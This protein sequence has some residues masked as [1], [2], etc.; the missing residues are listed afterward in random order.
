[1]TFVGCWGDPAGLL[2]NDYEVIYDWGDSLSDRPATFSGKAET[3][4]RA[5][6]TFS[7]FIEPEDERVAEGND[8]RRAGT[9]RHG[10]IAVRTGVR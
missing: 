1:M 4:K 6:A 9:P 7:A 10:H 8:G 3:H 2:P 5:F